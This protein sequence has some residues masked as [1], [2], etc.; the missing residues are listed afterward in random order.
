[1]PQEHTIVFLLCDYQENPTSD[2]IYQHTGM[3][4]HTLQEINADVS[5]RT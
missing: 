1:M 3:H 5:T 4:T 2:H